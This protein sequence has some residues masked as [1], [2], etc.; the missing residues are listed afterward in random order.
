M[1][2]PLFPRAGEVCGSCVC[3]VF[4]CWC[5]GC[6]RSACLYVLFVIVLV[7]SS[8]LG[9]SHE[10][11]VVKLTFCFLVLSMKCWLVA[12][13]AMDALYRCVMFVACWD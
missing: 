2:Q 7:V 9:C 3:L 1:V 5:R 6:S 11:S 4:G 8:L 10:L 13:V 12:L